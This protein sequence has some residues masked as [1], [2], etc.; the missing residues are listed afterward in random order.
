MIYNS[1]LKSDTSDDA[2]PTPSPSPVPGN[3]SNSNHFES[4][5]V[6]TGGIIGALA[7]VLMGG[8][9]GWWMWSRRRNQWRKRRSTARIDL[10]GDEVKPFEQP[11]PTPSAQ[12]GDNWISPI[13]ITASDSHFTPPH[14]SIP[15]PPLSTTS[16]FPQ[17]PIGGSHEESTQNTTVAIG[18]NSTL[19]PLPR[20]NK[21]LS[22]VSMINTLRMAPVVE[23]PVV[24]VVEGS[25]GPARRVNEEEALFRSGRADE[26]PD[27]MPPP[28]A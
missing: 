24:E 3:T 8:L 28:Y 27:V 2:T 6:I 11:R 23:A 7:I 18:G 9:G 26:E 25:Q 20:D 21:S 1:T 16:S 17:A 4:P 19:L 13:P 22:A 10:T 15:C 5:A 12:I 14:L